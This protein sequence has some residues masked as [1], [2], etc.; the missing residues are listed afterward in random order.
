MSVWHVQQ[1]C[2]FN[3]CFCRLIL[4]LM[5]NLL[6]QHRRQY[7]LTW[8]PMTAI[9]QSERKQSISYRINYELWLTIFYTHIWQL[10]TIKRFQN[11]LFLIFCSIKIALFKCIWNKLHSRLFLFESFWCQE[12]DVHFDCPVCFVLKNNCKF[13]IL[14]TQSRGFLSTSSSLS[15]LL[16]GSG[17][18]QYFHLASLGSD[19][20][21]LSIL[22]PGVKRPNLVPR[23]WTRLNSTYRPLLSS[24][25]WRSA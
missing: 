3:C 20:R 16:P 22:A 9:K 13:F 6:S 25:H 7:S 5:N 12:I 11:V 18:W 8:L 17:E 15:S 19:M 4:W 21:M 14:Q 1:S 23:S 24:C 2:F 10:W